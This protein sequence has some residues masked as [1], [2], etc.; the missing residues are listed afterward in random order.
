[1]EDEI[2][3]FL[4]KRGY[5]SSKDIALA[6]KKEQKEIRPFLVSLVNGRKIIK[7]GKKRG[8]KYAIPSNGHSNSENTILSIL[9]P[10]DFSSV[11]D[12]ISTSIDL[13]PDGQSYTV[14]ELSEV[15]YNF[16]PDSG[17]NKWDIIR[18][19]KKFVKTEKNKNAPLIVMTSKE[20]GNRLLYIKM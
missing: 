12:F 19:I 14:L 6:I 10:K 17:Y 13:I 4:S 7:T 8:T 9:N 16:C 18:N 20:M 2:I 3:N 11:D 1:M 5:V 15:I